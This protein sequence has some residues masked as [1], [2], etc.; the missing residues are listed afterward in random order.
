[1]IDHGGAINEHSP[2][3]LKPHG[4]Y[5]VSN[6]RDDHEHLRTIDERNPMADDVTSNP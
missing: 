4:M 1:M 2:M 6:M 5:G 3:I